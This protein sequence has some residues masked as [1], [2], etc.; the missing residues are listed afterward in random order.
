MRA[1]SPVG[2]RSFEAFAEEPLLTARTAAPYVA[3]MQ[4]SGGRGM[5][6]ALR[7]QMTTRRIGLLDSTVDERTLRKVYLAPLEDAIAEAGAGA[8]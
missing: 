3:S 1:R 7:R 2:G 5:P 6:E 4:K 8:C